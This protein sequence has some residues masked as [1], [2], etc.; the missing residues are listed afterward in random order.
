M[1]VDGTLMTEII[2]LSSWMRSTIIISSG[3][4][5]C[6]QSST[7]TD[8]FVP[9]A[10]N[11]EIVVRKFLINVFVLLLLHVLLLLLWSHLLNINS[12][13]FPPS[14]HLAASERDANDNSVSHLIVLFIRII[15]AAV[16]EGRHETTT[17]HCHCELS[18]V[19]SAADTVVEDGWA[20][21]LIKM[22]MMMMMSWSIVNASAERHCQQL[23][24]RLSIIAFH[25]ISIP[26]SLLSA[27]LLLLSILVFGRRGWD[28]TRPDGRNNCH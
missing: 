25:R 16:L 24:W 14:I 26:E 6:P 12:D 19:S 27:A 20:P 22:M 8:S 13:D 1:Y 10:C 4:W 11:T 21:T 9:L 15:P 17:C 18:S 2:E 23:H 7:A 5:I 3:I 28:E